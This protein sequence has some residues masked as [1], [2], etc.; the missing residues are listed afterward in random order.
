MFFGHVVNPF[1]AK[2]IKCKSMLQ[3]ELAQIQMVDHPHRRCVTKDGL[4]GFL[5][6]AEVGYNGIKKS[7]RIYC[8]AMQ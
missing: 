1:I 5:K 7:S 8:Y 3:I 6:Q 2:N 4:H